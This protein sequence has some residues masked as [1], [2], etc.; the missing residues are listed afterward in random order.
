M[1]RKGFYIVFEGGEGCGKTTQS[2]LFQN[3]LITKGID[4]KRVYE[5]GYTLLAKDMRRMLL[6]YKLDIDPLTEIFLFEAGRADLFN[7]EIIPSLKKGQTIISDRSAYSTL[8]YQGYGGGKDIDLIKK[9]N[10]AATRGIKPDLA[11]IVDINPKEGLKKETS[12]DRFAKKG[13]EYHQRVRLGFLEIAKENKNC[14]VIPYT[15]GIEKMQER[16][17]DIAQKRLGL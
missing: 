7:K 6:Q 9:L 4:S 2:Q 12:S 15:E 11:F 13:L 16:I 1:K 10:Y 3:Y 14:A 5:P 8:A 17:R